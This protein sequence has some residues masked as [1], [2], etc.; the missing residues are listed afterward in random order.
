[1]CFAFLFVKKIKIYVWS[2]IDSSGGPLLSVSRRPR[3]LRHTDIMVIH[4]IMLSLGST[5]VTA[6]CI[7][8]IIRYTN[9]TQ[10]CFFY[11]YYLFIQFFL[12]ISRDTHTHTHT[13][14]IHAFS[15]SYV[16]TY[17]LLIYWLNMFMHLRLNYDILLYCVIT[18]L[19]LFLITCCVVKYVCTIFLR[20][21][22]SD[23]VYFLLGTKYK[24]SVLS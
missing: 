10:S 14:V 5:A 7:I 9:I 12:L 22:V 16:W 4:N 20:R 13:Y 2:T 17:Y 11:G 18:D 1:M 15:C 24:I 6:N 23:L 8:I 21:S 3:R 19:F